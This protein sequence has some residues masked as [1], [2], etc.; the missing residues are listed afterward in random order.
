MEQTEGLAF[1]FSDERSSIRHR[2]HAARPGRYLDALDTGHQVYAQTTLV[3][4]TIPARVNDARQ[5]LNRIVMAHHYDY[6]FCLRNF[7]PYETRHFQPVH[8]GHADIQ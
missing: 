2:T 4:A 6:D 7:P 8:A 1:L 3:N 5:Q